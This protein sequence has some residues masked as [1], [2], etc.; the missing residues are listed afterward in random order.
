MK[1]ISA[2]TQQQ[3]IVLG[4]LGFGSVLSTSESHRILSE[5][6][7]LGIRVLD[8]A[9]SYGWGRARTV[10]ASYM[11]KHPSQNWAVWDKIGMEMDFSG[12]YPTAKRSLPLSIGG[13]RAEIHKVLSELNVESLASC[14][15]HVPLYLPAEHYL[16]EGLSGALDDGLIHS[17]GISNHSEDQLRRIVRSAASEGFRPAHAQVQLS[18]LEQRGSVE[19]VPLCKSY[20]IKVAANRVLARGL[21]AKLSVGQSRRLPGSVRLRNYIEKHGSK[22]GALRAVASDRCELSMTQLALAWAWGPGGADYVVIGASSPEHLA[23]VAESATL[24]IS[25]DFWTDFFL[26]ERLGGVHF[27]DL[28]SALFDIN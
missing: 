18:M 1:M 27:T 17:V 3:K 28:P 24:E 10:I 16:I 13:L 4:T 19:F 12:D 23:E 5:A 26:D 15:L 25:L 20:G 11:R 6:Y 8:C 2:R 22:I 14:Q 7:H 21:L 9:P